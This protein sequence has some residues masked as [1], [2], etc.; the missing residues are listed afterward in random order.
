MA[1]RPGR[2][3]RMQT[4]VDELVR[5]VE[6][7]L[8]AFD[9]AAI[10]TGPSVFFHVEALRQRRSHPS[11]RAALVDRPLVVTVYA[12]LASWGM[13]RMGGP[14]KLV[15]FD[16]FARELGETSRAVVQ[17]RGSPIGGAERPRGD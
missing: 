8:D 1:L 12:T 10:F 6:E 14:A 5:R 15:A 4:R 9:D 7:C 2:Q 17:T 13:H 3:K 11:V 16:V